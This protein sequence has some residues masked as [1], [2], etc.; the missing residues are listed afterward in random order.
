MSLVYIPA[1]DPDESPP[2][3]GV[4][5]TRQIAAELQSLDGLVA[6]RPGS[7]RGALWKTARLV[8]SAVS[9]WRLDRSSALHYARYHGPLSE[10]RADGA[11]TCIYEHQ[12]GPVRMGAMAALDLGFRVIALPHN[13]EA[14]ASWD[15]LDPITRKTG[16]AYLDWERKFLGRMHAVYAISRDET[17]L[18]RNLGVTAFYYPYWPDEAAFQE[19]LTARALRRQDDRSGPILVLGSALNGP[20]EEGMRRLI[21]GLA[22][23]TSRPIVVAGRGVS[24]LHSAAIGDR[25]E[26]RS[27]VSPDELTALCARAACACIHQE[28]G[29]GALTRIRHLLISG[30]P[31]VCNTV[32]ARDYAGEPGVS[33]YDRLQD[34][35]PLCETAAGAIPEPPRRQSPTLDRL[36]VSDEAFHP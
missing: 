10:L 31:V 22:S 27:D 3:G 20:T 30:V 23:A 12:A 17:C 28:R 35:A 4:L 36:L 6:V 13:M 29:A 32:A 14:L 24:R 18:L 1:F 33:V 2:H 11:S 19:A 25:V 5:R 8:A 21:A 9:R 26:F 34:A 16:A 15:Q 7:A